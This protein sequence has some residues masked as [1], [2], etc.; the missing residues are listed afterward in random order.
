[1][2]PQQRILLELSYEALENGNSQTLATKPILTFSAGMP[3]SSVNK[4][5]TGV[6]IGSSCRDYADLLRRDS[7]KTE[8]YQPIGN[9]PTMLANR[10][11]Y[12]FDLNGPSVTID[13]GIAPSRFLSSDGR[14]YTYDDRA[15]GFGRG[16]GAACVVLKPFEDALRDGDVIRA[17]IR[18]SGT[19]Q[20]GKT[21]GISVPNG[22]AQVELMKKTYEE[23]GLH[24]SHTDYIEAHG[25]GT[26][27]GDPI[28][29]S[30]LSQ[31]LAQG[32]PMKQPLLIG[33]I[34]SNI[35]HLEGASGIAAVVKVVLMLEKGFILPNFDFQKASSRIPMERWNIEVPKSL[36]P[37][38]SDGIRRAS[39][40]NF[41]FGGSNAHAILDDATSF[42]AQ[43]DNIEKTS[44]ANTAEES[45]YRYMNGCADCRVPSESLVFLLSS[46]DEISGKK[47]AQN[48]VQYI[49]DHQD[50]DANEL[51]R[52]LAYT[53]SER[54]S[55]LPWRFASRAQ[56]PS[57]LGETLSDK[58]IKFHNIHDSKHLGFIFTG[59]D[60]LG[61]DAQTSQV[62]DAHI[63]QCLTTALQ[64]ALVDLLAS[65]NI[66]PA[67]VAGH[68]SGEIAAAYC[69]GA[70]SQR[71]AMSVAYHRGIVAL[72]LKDLRDGA[73]LA[74]GMSEKDID[75]LVASLATGRAKVACIN[76]GSSVTVSG[77]RDAIGELS[78]ILEAKDVFH[79]RLAVQVAYHS[80]HMEDVADEYRALLR[81][82]S[83]ASSNKVDFYSSVTGDPVPS[84]KLGPE[85]WVS[86]MINPVQFQSAARKLLQ[87][88]GDRSNTVD[89]L[90]EI[91]P[92]SA[93]Q[94]PIKQI[95]NE[96]G[97]TRASYIP[98]LVRN[99]NAIH[100]CQAMIAMLTQA[101]Y[102]TNLQAVNSPELSTSGKMLSNLPI[103][104]WD[105]SRSYW[106]KHVKLSEE[107]L[108]Q[109]TRSDTLGVKVKGSIPSEPRWRN[110][111]RPAE[112]P[113]I[114][115]HVV[116]SSILYP[117]AG[118]LAMA[119]QARYQHAQ[120]TSESLTGYKLREISIGHALIVSQESDDLETLVS[121]RPYHESLRELSSIWHEFTVHSS[122]DNKS[123]TEHCRGLISIEQAIQ[124]TDVDGGR[125]IAEEIKHFGR[126]R[127]AFSDNCITTIDDQEIYKSLER[128]GL[129][130]GPTFKNLHDVRVAAHQCYAEVT[131][132]DT[133]SI[134]PAQFEYPFIIHPATL[135]SAF[136]ALFPVD[137]RHRNIEQGTPVPTFIEELFISNSVAKTPGHIF[138]VYAENGAMAG[139]F[140]R[141][142]GKG[143]AS[144]AVFDK[145]GHEN[146]PAILVK[147]LVFKDLPYAVP[148]ESSDSER[149]ACYQ[150]EWHTDPSLLSPMQTRE[151]SAHCRRP[152]TESDHAALSQQA[153]FYYAENALESLTDD[154]TMKMQPHHRKLCQTLTN[155]CRTVREGQLGMFSTDGWLQLDAVGRA[156]VCSSIGQTPFGIL[157][158][159][160]GESLTQIV[161]QQTDPLAVM[162]E[163]D[164]LERYYRT[165]E[166]I[167]QSYEQAAV[168]IQLLG[169]KNPHLKI[170][171]LGAGTG[172]ATLPI[173]EALSTPGEGFPHL[174]SYDFTDLSPAFFEKAKKKLE[175]WTEWL[176]FKRIDAEKDLVQQ[177]CQPASYDLVIAAN[178]IHA[179]SHVER[180]MKSI[181]KILKPGV[182][183]S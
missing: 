60:E 164:R 182:P 138:S 4:T 140:D 39:L 87:A 47:Q 49:T 170:L 131:I 132:P 68:S 147:G 97:T 73:M 58:N 175:R 36:R 146:K 9:A 80:H 42:I 35:G 7:E 161:R 22:D 29:A 65:W 109:S 151:I 44:N 106:T 11:S 115:D 163:N 122:T 150:L 48:L 116:Q 167:K 99:Q 157:L 53:L 162:I 100:T 123:W 139:N 70:L 17:V 173:L 74:V 46:S 112:I 128:L 107:G 28:E 156:N 54:R 181:R 178:V 160:V 33:S 168:F 172:G 1:M 125:K 20:D 111:V 180:T 152:Y 102:P 145:V 113:W 134:M 158:G 56:S 174:A 171:E 76:S 75:P 154:E 63:S 141:K 43:R 183:Y 120:Q 130:F 61:K 12:F 86:N 37:W 142:I 14:C 103:Y 124:G 117:A 2:D 59:Q 32:R 62:G 90:L 38:Q 8:L 57:Q 143:N 148:E 144:V 136:H 177:G 119:I 153:G 121:L 101:G 64:I 94:G 23:V 81:D 55:K 179:T 118:F 95:I 26:P 41:G 176:T 98:T 166:P 91:G 19:N 25:T 149:R 169:M 126:I 40:N 137:A 16:E 77:D 133:A 13:T 89:I 135:D 52:D 155:Y 21:H 127:S 30:S 18:N 88:G 105:H 93:L 5:S 104:A 31:Y 45:T 96:S 92:H 50:H 67:R 66:Y 114:N 24:P 71:D 6:F 27:T 3:I 69:A 159:P 82:V 83:L 51:M 84:S 72:K 78:K 10:I 129:S 79:R 110:I 15:N 85:Y 34:K 108:T 165:W